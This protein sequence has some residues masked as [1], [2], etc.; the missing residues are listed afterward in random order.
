MSYHYTDAKIAAMFINRHL[1]HWPKHASS[2]CFIGILC[3]IFLRHVKFFATSD[4]N[5]HQLWLLQQTI[6]AAGRTLP[7]TH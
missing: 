7:S 2:K 4:A 5:I 1:G 6:S 3:P